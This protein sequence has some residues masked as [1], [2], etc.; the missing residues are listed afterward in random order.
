MECMG[1]S[2]RLSYCTCDMNIH[3][4]H[5]KFGCVGSRLGS[6]RN[7]P[8]SRMKV[9]MARVL[10]TRIY[11]GRVFVKWMGKHFFAF[12]TAEAVKHIEENCIENMS[13]L[14][15]QKYWRTCRNV[16]C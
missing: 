12:G 15:L 13:V 10:S 14:I 11:R 1:S 8:L 2:S 7:Y 3:L 16:T 6:C 9:F 4:N 5:F